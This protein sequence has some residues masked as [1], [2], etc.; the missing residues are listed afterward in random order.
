[1]EPSSLLGFAIII[2]GFFLFRKWRAGRNQ[3]GT[4]SERRKNPGIDASVRANAETALRDR[5]VIGGSALNAPRGFETAYNRV[6]AGVHVDSGIKKEL[7]AALAQNQCAGTCEKILLPGQWEWPEFDKWKKIFLNDGK[8][9][10]V[11]KHY[12][13]LCIT[14][15]ENFRLSTML[16][17]VH[18]KDIKELFQKLQIEIPPKIKKSELIELA[19]QK[20][21]IETIQEK[22]PDIYMNLK[23][24]FNSRV[25]RGKC[26]ILEHTITALSYH[27]RD[28]Y[29]N[30]RLKIDIIPG[31]PVEAKY[32]KGKGKISEYNIPPFFPGDRSG[33]QFIRK[34]YNIG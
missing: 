5:G 25:N 18:V 9:P 14:N 23:K 30:G 11:W 4:P 26:A 34:K 20:I 27:L 31:C 22:C 13:E 6:M 1:M 15:F 19:N 17:R 8:F 32:A 12:P 21:T 28:F 16:D 3:A 10:Y 7:Y 2:G 24:D 33:V 29:T